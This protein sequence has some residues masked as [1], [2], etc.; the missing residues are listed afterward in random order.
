M[1][2]TAGLARL[3][4]N[5]VAFPTASAAAGLI[6]LERLASMTGIQFQREHIQ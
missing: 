2:K 1:E 3:G 5:A 4:K 6:D